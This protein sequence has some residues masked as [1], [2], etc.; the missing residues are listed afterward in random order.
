MGTGIVFYISSSWILTD[1]TV[2]VRAIFPSLEEFCSNVLNYWSSSEERRKGKKGTNNT[3]RIDMLCFF[4]L[5]TWQKSVFLSLDVNQTPAKQRWPYWGRLQSSSSSRLM[6]LLP[7]DSEFPSKKDFIVCWTFDVFL[8][9]HVSP[10]FLEK[11]SGWP[12][13]LTVAWVASS[14]HSD[15]SHDCLAAGGYNSAVYQFNSSGCRRVAA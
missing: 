9:R 8:F 15:W 3:L 11:G 14:T 6:D 1:Y 4:F 2:N 10:K 7:T 12:V 5:P 13:P